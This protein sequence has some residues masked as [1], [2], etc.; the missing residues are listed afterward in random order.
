MATSPY[1]NGLSGYWVQLGAFGQRDGALRLQQQVARELPAL[2]GSL[3]VFSERGTNR[4]QAGPY[5]S[6]ES[7]RETADQIRNG[8]QL[9]PVIVERR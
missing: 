6:R 4:L 2:A 5:A 9:A 8:L 3:N 7:A 1:A